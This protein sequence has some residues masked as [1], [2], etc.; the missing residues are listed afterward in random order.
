MV[1]QETL[2]AL[3]MSG[4]FYGVGVGPGD[5]QLLTLQAL[6]VLQESEVI[7]APRTKGENTMALDIVSQVVDL[8]DKEIVW[9]DFAMKRDPKARASSQRNNTELLLAPLRQGKSVAMLSIGDASTFSNVSYFIDAVKEDGHEVVIVAGITA[10]SAAA[11]KW[12]VSL[13][14]RD[15][16]L[17]IIPAGATDLDEVLALKGSKI[18]MKPTM[19]V[20]ELIASLERAGVLEE[21]RLAER[22][23]WPEERT[24][25]SMKGVTEE[26]GYFTTLFVPAKE[27]G[28]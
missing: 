23:T 28:I 24:L 21:T 5:P 14:A 12:Q 6:K 19:P 25:D 17:T 20:Q 11:A 10:F 9:L 16:P 3:V 2:G 8:R 1:P 7:A 22:I 15:E 18:L 4:R 27:K 13:T 26:L